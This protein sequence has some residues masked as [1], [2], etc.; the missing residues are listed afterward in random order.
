MSTI[1]I[2]K[3]DKLRKLHRINAFLVSVSFDNLNILISI[4]YQKTAW[5]AQIT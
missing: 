4:I 5:K 1:L 2:T 3:V